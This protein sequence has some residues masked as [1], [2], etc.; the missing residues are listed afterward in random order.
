MEEKQKEIIQ[1]IIIVLKKIDRRDYEIPRINFVTDLIPNNGS[2]HSTYENNFVTKFNEKYAI[3][4]DLDEIPNRKDLQRQLQ[5]TKKYIYSEY[6]DPKVERYYEK[7]KKKYNDFVEDKV[8]FETIPDFFIHKDQGDKSGQNQKL[9]IEFKTEV[10]IPEKRFMWDF[11]K[12]NLYV[13][14]YNYQ[15]ACFICINN[16]KIYVEEL[17]VQYLEGKHYL[18]RNLKN[19]YILIQ[20]SFDSN[21]Q[22]FSLEDFILNNGYY[23]LS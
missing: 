18:A 14:K 20:E 21:V 16:S 3:L 10:N 22:Y 6:K 7:L 8:E 12:L 2:N 23:E 9:I 11:F 5:I 17:L 15:T 4:E 13:E 1:N 19:I